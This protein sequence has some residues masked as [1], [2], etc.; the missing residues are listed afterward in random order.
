MHMWLTLLSVCILLHTISYTT[1][2]LGDSAFLLNNQ[3][4]TSPCGSRW[5]C[6]TSS[7]HVCCITI[8]LYCY[9]SAGTEEKYSWSAIKVLF[10]NPRSAIKA[11]LMPSPP[12][13]FIHSIS[14]SMQ[15]SLQTPLFYSTLTHPVGG[16]HRNQR[17]KL[18]M[19][20]WNVSLTILQ[21]CSCGGSC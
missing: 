16:K 11:Y 14:I 5:G 13:F 21:N 1:A 19:H 6:V 20:C 12:F 17:V 18:A 15:A 7:S 8:T 3:I 10:E 2:L 4:M 9:S